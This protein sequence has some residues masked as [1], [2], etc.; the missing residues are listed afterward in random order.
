MIHVACLD[1]CREL[2]ELSKWEN[3]YHRWSKNIYGKDVVIDTSAAGSTVPAYD[4]GYL[5]RK[6]PQNSWIGY[7]DTSGHRGY[8]LAYTFAWN[9][10]GDYI[11]KIAE[12]R[13]D[14][15]EDAAC[16]LAIELFQRGILKQD[17][18]EGE[19]SND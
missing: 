15:P 8:A 19:R 2:Y 10:K 12:C 16:L 7:T 1:L 6:L 3:I 18:E 5:L 9:E 4:L 11:S 14:T 17:Q 13:A